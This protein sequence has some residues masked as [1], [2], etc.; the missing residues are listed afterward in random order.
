LQEVLSLVKR[1]MTV[2]VIRKGLDTARGE[3]RG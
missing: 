1:E 2:G 3:K